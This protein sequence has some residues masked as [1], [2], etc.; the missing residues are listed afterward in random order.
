LALN[1]SAAHRECALRSILT[2][3]QED[4]RSKNCGTHEWSAHQART[5]MA[6][7]MGFGSVRELFEESD[8]PLSR[9]DWQS[10]RASSVV[11]SGH[12]DEVW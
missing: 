6:S 7:A 1:R 10:T 3:A 2:A 5:P 8:R 4:V 12:S 11:N 9:W